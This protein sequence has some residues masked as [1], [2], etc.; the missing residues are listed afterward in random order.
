MA[1]TT[2]PA[3]I[4]AGESLSN[5]VDL[6]SPSAGLMRIVLPPEW[7]SRAWLTFLYSADGDNFGDVYRQDGSVA[8]ITVTP[9]AVVAMKDIVRQG[10]IRFR[11]GPPGNPIPQEAERT[12]LCVME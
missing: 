6:G 12:I 9:G 3:V 5:I 8:V 10:F 4:P 1:V 2:I 7:S 11:S